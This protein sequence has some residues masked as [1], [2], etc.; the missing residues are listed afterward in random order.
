MLGHRLD[1]AGIHKNIDYYLLRTSHGSTLSRLVQS[2]VLSRF[3]RE[4]SWTAFCEALESDLSD[5]QGGTTAEGIHL[6]AMAGTVDLVQRIYTGLE[7]RDGVL[8]FN[9]HLPRHLGSLEFAVRY[10]GMW[11][12]V[13][14]TSTELALSPRADA[15]TEPVR[16]GVVDRVHFLKPGY[17]QLF[18]LT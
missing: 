7:I 3:D 10:R 1:P 6:G 18:S 9:P 17:Q 15:R 2:A 11:L 16:I 12:D 8:F 5:V 14:V 4:T 13:R